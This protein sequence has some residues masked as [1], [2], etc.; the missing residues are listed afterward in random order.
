M[1]PVQFRFFL[2]HSSNKSASQCESTAKA[3]L[4]INVRCG[5]YRL[6]LAPLELARAFPFTGTGKSARQLSVRSLTLVISITGVPKF[7]AALLAFT[8]MQ[9]VQQQYLEDPKFLK[10]LLYPSPFGIGV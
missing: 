1:V 3:D 5:L 4:A 10:P 9:L 6:S 7:S 2:C 8:W